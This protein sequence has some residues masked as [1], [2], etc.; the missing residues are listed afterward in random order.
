ME[1]L[2]EDR[3]EGMVVGSDIQDIDRRVDGM[4]SSINMVSIGT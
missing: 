2:R 4:G 3:R 1:D